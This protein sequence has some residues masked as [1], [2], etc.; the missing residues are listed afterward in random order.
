MGCKD[1]W[2]RSVEKRMKAAGLTWDSRGGKLKSKL[3]VPTRYMNERQAHTEE[4][5]K[6]SVQL[7]RILGKDN[8]QQWNHQ[9]AV[10]QSE[11]R[12]IEL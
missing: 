9:V 12:R 3:Y 5:S 2:R 6:W 1:T 8:K 4:V 11:S 10:P 7:L